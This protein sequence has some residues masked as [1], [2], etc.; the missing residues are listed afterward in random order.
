MARTCSATA[1]T[2]SFIRAG[3]RVPLLSRTAVPSPTPRCSA[4]YLQPEGVQIAT[5]DEHFAV[6]SSPGDVVLLGNTSWRIQRIEAAGRVL[7]EDAHGAPPTLPFWFGEAPQ[8]TAVLS[9][10]VG[11]LRERISELTA[12]IAPAAVHPSH[13]EVAACMAWLMEE[14]GLCASAARQLI[15]YIVAGRAVLGAVPS[16]TTIIAERFFDEGGGQQLILHAPFGGR[17]NKAWG[18]AL[19]KRFCRGFNFELQAAATDNGINISLAEQH[20]FPLSD[21]F[22]FLTEQTA[23]A[24]LEQAAIASPIFKT[25]WRWAANRSLQLLRMSKGKRIAP[26]IQRTRSEDLLASVFPQAAACFET[27]VGNIQIPNHPLVNEVMQDVLQE[28]MDLEGLNE[29]LRGIAAG[30]IRCLAVDTAVPSQFAHE[31]INANP[32]AFLD[33]AGLEERR[34]RAV[35][36]RRDLPPAFRRAQAVST[37]PPS[38]PSAAK[39]SPTSETNTNFTICCTPSS[40]SPSFSSNREPRTLNLVLTPA[41]GPSSS[42]ASLKPA[43]LKSLTSTAFPAGP[44]PS[45]FRMSP[46]SAPTIQNK[47]LNWLQKKS[48]SSNLFKAGYKL[49][50]PLQPAPSPTA[51]PSRPPPSSRPF[52]PWRCKAC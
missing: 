7:V 27:I 23:K 41:T 36:L 38:T 51:S 40:P 48:P 22:H 3:A 2:A 52:S 19:R 32:Y 45:A 50:A 10:G 9:G 46:Y 43:V 37:K 21:V 6:D 29:I 12:N 28:A 20:S 24:L 33:D 14:C 13:P 5:L 4:S 11:E 44:P 34:T 35:N 8:R 16:S 49:P 31:L 18:L 25:R 17:I 39:S 47:T 1:S 26:Q 42:N 30:T 15:A